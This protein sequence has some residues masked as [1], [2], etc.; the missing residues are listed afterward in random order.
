VI[1][2]I[3]IT[4][5]V[6]D[7]AFRLSGELQPLYLSQVGGMSVEQIGWLKS[8]LGI[9]MMSVTLPAGWLA[10]K[11]GERVPIV[12]GFFLQSVALMI[13]V[14]SSG[15]TSFAMAAVVFGLGLG[16]LI[17]AYDSLISKAVPENLRGTAFGLFQTSLGVVSL[18]APW[19][20]A[21]LWERL[22]ARVPFVV[23]AIAALFSTVPAW[24]KFVL[25]RKESNSQAAAQ[26]FTTR[27]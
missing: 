21:Q 27:A 14:Q 1:T 11:R 6:Q 13:F 3:L 12:I 23:T 25:P 8:I 24:W 9:A 15:F 17:P 16:T 7:V 10:D 22:G 2:W 19:I 26:A 5:G 18:P 20:G 4:D